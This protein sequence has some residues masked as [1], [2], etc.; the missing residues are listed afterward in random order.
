MGLKASNKLVIP[1]CPNCHRNG[2]YGVALHAGIKGWEEYHNTSEEIL[3]NKVK[4]LLG[5]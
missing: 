4:E 3:L 1:L 2:G 5:E